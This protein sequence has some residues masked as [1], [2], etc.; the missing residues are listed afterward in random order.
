MACNATIQCGRW[1]RDWDV[2]YNACQSILFPPDF[3]THGPRFIMLDLALTAQSVVERSDLWRNLARAMLVA[4][5]KHSE[6]TEGR[7]LCNG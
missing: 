2:L 1:E 4:S 6:S 3:L 5:R 7:K